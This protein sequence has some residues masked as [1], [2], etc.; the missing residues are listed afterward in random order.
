MTELQF[1]NKKTGDWET[2]AEN[3]KP[4]EFPGRYEA[5]AWLEEHHPEVDNLRQIRC[6]DYKY[7]DCCG[8]RVWLSGFTNTCD[9]GADY[10]NSG[11]LLAPRS[12]WGAETGETVSDILAA[13]TD[14]NRRG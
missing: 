11:D 14:R 9:C 3:G 10:N 4:I 12:Q 8:R 13:D 2:A 6:F 5:E 1:F 7:C